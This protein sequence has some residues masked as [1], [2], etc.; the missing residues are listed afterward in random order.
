MY[1]IPDVLLVAK[2]DLTTV[3]VVSRETILHVYLKQEKNMDVEYL[4]ILLNQKDDNLDRQIKSIINKKDINN[5]TPLHIAAQRCPQNAIRYLLEAGSNIGMKNQFGEAAIT[6]IP[7]DTF[8]AFLN[9]Y[10]MQ[11]N[12]MDVNS[13]DLQLSFDYR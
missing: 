12:D 13:L 10:C 1:F 4:K 11:T 6:Q 8:E 9:E 2:A 7:A 3:K 5:Q